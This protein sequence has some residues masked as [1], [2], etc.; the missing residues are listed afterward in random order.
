M[1]VGD[2]GREWTAS[3]QLRSQ[4]QP[5]ERRAIRALRRWLTRAPTP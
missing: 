4:V 2:Q 5:E 1:M 3:Q